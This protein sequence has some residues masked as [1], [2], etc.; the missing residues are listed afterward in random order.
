VARARDENRNTG[1]PALKEPEARERLMAAAR[2]R[3]AGEA[4]QARRCVAEV[5]SE[6][7]GN[8]EANGLMAALAADENDFDQ[9]YRWAQRSVDSDPRAAGAHFT[10]GRLFQA[11]GRLAEAEASYL[12]AI[13]LAPE[14]AKTHNNLGCVQHMLGKLDLAVASYRR[15]LA[16]DA[17]LPQ[18][19]QN[20]AAITSDAALAEGAIAG[21]LRQLR[22]NPGDA[23]AHNNL[24]NVYRELGRH[25]EALASFEAAVACDPEL[26][27]AHFSRAH[28]LLL[29]GEYSTGWKEHEWRWKVK[30]LGAPM[31]EFREPLW[32]GA[33]LPGKTLLLHAEQGLGDTIQFIR[34]A[35]MA[36]QRCGAVILECQPQIAGLLRPVRGLSRVIARGDPL[37]AFDAHLP[38]MSLPRIFETT[39]DS[40]PWNGPY[41]G[42][43]P[44]RIEHW[45][46]AL[47]PG[48]RLHV[49]L[50][51]AGRSQYWD[52][53]KRSIPLA[54]FAPLAGLAGLSLYSLQWGEAA[55]QISS[56]PG[57]M[58]IRDFGDA[59]RDFSEMAALVASLD[60]VISV[61]SAVNH[62]AGAMGAPAWLLAT[63]A[64]DW[65]WLLERDDSP[66]YPS[67]RIFRQRKSGDWS[68]VIERV[69]AALA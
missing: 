20:L 47:E 2:H 12:R 32:D 58:R 29:C 67:V 16:L 65:R 11:E 44:G 27:E 42:A 17:S 36:A 4:A 38:V 37:P 45:R 35:P 9:G 62:L 68:G 6:H 14:S 41:I 46:H 54:A 64:P 53:R 34:Y 22:Q 21:Y 15:A 61:D 57:G 30:A 50:A 59:I 3:N 69:A 24:G 7:P 1:G 33:A 56:L 39:V 23:W 66:W 18:A 48:A 55:A 13:E 28:E 63:H 19:S 26:A 10:F 8:S 31:P 52:D 49:G 60:L 40:V 25:R 43:E 51:W 5:L